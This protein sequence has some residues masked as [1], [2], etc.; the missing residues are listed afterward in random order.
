[1]KRHLRF[2]DLE[3]QPD[4]F[5]PVADVDV[6]KDADSRTERDGK[7]LSPKEDQVLP[8]GNQTTT[9]NSSKKRRKR[10]K[11]PK[12]PGDLEE[13]ET[14]EGDTNT[15]KS[16]T[17]E[18]NPSAAESSS[19]KA[20]II[21][22]STNSDSNAG[23]ASRDG[24]G[25]KRHNLS[26]SVSK[27]MDFYGP[28]NIENYVPASVIIDRLRSGE[29]PKRAHAPRPSTAKADKREP[30]RMDE[31]LRLAIV[32]ANDRTGGLSEA[33]LKDMEEQVLKA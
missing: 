10:N 12:N 4:W 26:D 25:S 24:K 1:M 31:S 18:T 8:L 14:K 29:K 16:N 32:D 7:N 3:N 5:R 22:N 13:R 33:I 28:V 30:N 20:A 19:D 21:V 9:E 23:S 6:N 2:R 15:S 11:K 17:S 27:L